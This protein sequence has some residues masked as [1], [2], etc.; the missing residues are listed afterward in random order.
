M[1]DERNW[2]LLR[3]PGGQSQAIYLFL[4]QSHQ[5]QCG[6]AVPG[7][8]CP[9]QLLQ[10]QLTAALH[11]VP[12]HQQLCALQL[13]PPD[14]GAQPVAAWLQ[15]RPAELLQQP[16]EYHR[17]CDAPRLALWGRPWSTRGQDKRDS[18]APLGFTGWSWARDSLL[19]TSPLPACRQPQAWIL[20]LPL[21]VSVLPLKEELKF[22]AHKINHFKA[23][24]SEAFGTFTVLCDYHLY[25]V[26]KYF[27][28]PLKK[29]S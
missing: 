14:G 12:A 20:A 21:F 1:R 4:L 6:W 15:G 26:P 16:H 10:P 9:L 23:N 7:G 19:G 2:H 24:S 3:S 25:L 8:R 17:C 5:E 28:H 18:P 29:T 22:I 11:P 27:H 13:R